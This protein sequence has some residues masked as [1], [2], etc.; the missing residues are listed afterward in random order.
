MASGDIMGQGQSPIDLSDYVE[1]D[2]PSPRFEYGGAA[3]LIEHQQVA[4]IVH[5]NPDNQLFIAEERF[6]LLQFHW[7]TPAEHTIDGDEFVMEL[8]LVH[9]N[10]RRAL[11]VVGILYR[12]DAPDEAIE[13]L[14]QQTP[15]FGQDLRSDITLLAADYAPQS[16][17][18]YHYIGSLT[19]PPYS[20]PV[21]WYVSRATRS[22]SQDQLERLQALTNGPN[23]RAL[24]D[25]NGRTIVC[26]G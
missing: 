9:Q 1:A 16:D 18:C 23:A 22:I 6:E 14:I 19:A 4:P 15:P 12:L 7:H 10:D 25:R 8:H 3:V 13:R 20:E 2:S 24:Q 17:G 21:Q 5:F 26:V 11:L